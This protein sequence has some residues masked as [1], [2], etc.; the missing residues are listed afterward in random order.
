MFAI[1]LENE[2]YN[3]NKFCIFPIISVSQL[4]LTLPLQRKKIQILSFSYVYFIPG[5]LDLKHFRCFL[6][7]TQFMF[8]FPIVY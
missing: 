4:F 1:A 6:T 5:T 2:K 8:T 7:F 3:M